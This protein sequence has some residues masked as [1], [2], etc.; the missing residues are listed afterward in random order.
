MHKMAVQN[1]NKVAFSFAY[2]PV[3]SAFDYSAPRGH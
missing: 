2:P 3:S 1:Q